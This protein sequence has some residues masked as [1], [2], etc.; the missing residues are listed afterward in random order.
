M[1]VVGTSPDVAGSVAQGRERHGGV[2]SFGTVPAPTRAHAPTA[3]QLTG[4]RSSSTPVIV[5]VESDELAG[6]AWKQ[7]DL[8][9]LS[10]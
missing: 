7:A 2:R 9:G 5:V 6:R 8:K 10:L 3:V 1:Q 4:L